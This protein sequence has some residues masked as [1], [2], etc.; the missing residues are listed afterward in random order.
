MPRTLW[1]AE[2]EDNFPFVETEDQMLAIDAVKQDMESTVPMDRV[3]VGDVGYGKT[4]V[5]IRAAF[6][7]VQ[8]GM[9][10]AVL[11]PTT[12]LAQQHFDTFS[13]RMTGFPVKIEV[14]S[15]FTSKKE[16]KDIF[17]GLADGSVDIEEEVARAHAVRLSGITQK[18]VR[19]NL[20]TCV[21]TWSQ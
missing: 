6:K 14:L 1:Q 10:V 21:H 15:R 13:E 17:K 8:D 3:V 18:Q 4:E 2:M 16:A 7:A 5:A 19:S 11:V 20:L 9:Q 12:L